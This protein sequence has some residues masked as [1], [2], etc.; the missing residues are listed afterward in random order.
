MRKL[1][2]ASVLAL[3][4]VGCGDDGHDVEPAVISGGGV[5]DPGIDGEV[6]ATVLSPMTPP[7]CRPRNTRAGTEGGE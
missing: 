4:L 2:V 6:N 3:G 5:H 1:H 7:P